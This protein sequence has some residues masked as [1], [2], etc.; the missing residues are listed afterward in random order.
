MIGFPEGSPG[1]A[2]DTGRNGRP[3][4]AWVPAL[5]RER[6]LELSISAARAGE[7]ACAALRLADARLP[8]HW[9]PLARLL[10]PN[11]GVA[12]SAIEGLREP[13]ESVLV[14]GRTGAGGPAGWVADNLVV[15]DQALDTAHAPLTVDTLHLWHRRLMRHG[16]LPSHMTGVLRPVMGWIGGASPLDAAYVPPPPGRNRHWFIVPDLLRLWR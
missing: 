5:L 9:A 14:A 2:L 8:D 10:L 16:T 3:V 1:S 6:S 7:Q 13:I 12:S 11:E 15:I 4:Q